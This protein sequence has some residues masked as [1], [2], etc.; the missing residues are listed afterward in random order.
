MESCRSKGTF[1]AWGTLHMTWSPRYY[2][3]YRHVLKDSDL[4]P[5][6]HTRAHDQY[7]SSTLIGGKKRSRSKF[8]T[9]HYTW[10]TNGVYMW[11]MQDGCK[12]YMDSY[13][14]SCFMV[15]W[16]IFKNHLVEVGRPENHWETMALR[17]LTIIGLFYFIVC[18]DMCELY[19]FIDIAF[20][21][22]SGHIWLHT[23]LEGPWPHYTISEVCWD[24]LWTLSLGL[25]QVH[26]HGSWL[27]CEVAL[28]ST[29]TKFIFL[30]I[31]G[32][33]V[34]GSSDPGDFL[35]IT[36]Y[37]FTSSRFPLLNWGIFYEIPLK[38]SV[39]LLYSSLERQPVIS[40][41]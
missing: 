36:G 11:M 25:S 19:T 3:H 32:P 24:N 23:K 34:L 10:G 37:T 1:S 28:S 22:G 35:G 4:R 13:M 20:G 29:N 2:T 9:S 8:A 30:S 17:T 5:T 39:I 14:A 21:W 26:G 27:V 31:P 38:W 33:W 7:T 15:T 16:T 12:V 40:Q 41:T 18:E 6:S